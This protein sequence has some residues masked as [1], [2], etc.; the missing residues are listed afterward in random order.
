MD[1]SFNELSLKKAENPA[2]AKQWM[3]NLLT[4]YKSANLK[5]FKGL[6]LPRNIASVELA[7]NYTI[8]NWLYDGTVDQVVRSVFLTQAKYPFVEDAL[9]QED[10]EGHVLAEFQYKGKI[11]FGL[12]TACLFGS[13][14]ISFDNDDEWDTVSIP[15]HAAYYTENDVFQESEEQ[16]KHCCKL[17]HLHLLEKWILSVCKP[18]ISNGKILWL[19]RGEYFPHLSFCSAVENQL[20]PFHENHPQFNQIKKR[21][22]EMEDY[23]RDWK[24]A[25]FD[26]K[27][28]SSK[29]TP[30]SDTRM[31]QFQDRLT[32][33]CADE[34]KRLFSWHFRYTPGAGRIYFYPDAETKK[35]HVGY[36]GLKLAD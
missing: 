29:V 12:G 4:V 22:F 15:I 7:A 13:L 6:R 8:A 14:A 5:G 28:I 20:S 24:S 33:L 35:I 25:S 9:S 21:L 17:C 30:E 31:K 36:I 23:C 16:T 18:F 3:M 27:K 10:D 19:K 2:M 32:I 34:K 1:V 11:A 26:H